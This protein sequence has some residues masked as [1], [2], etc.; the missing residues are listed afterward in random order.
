MTKRKLGIMIALVGF[1]VYLILGTG[2]HG[3]DLATIAQFSNWTFE[4][5]IIPNPARQ[6][7]F[8][9]PFHLTYLFFGRIGYLAI[10][11]IMFMIL[12]RS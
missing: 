1:L 10:I 8:L 5:W 3:D 4:E 9:L 6:E 12:L 2:L 11:L 7:I